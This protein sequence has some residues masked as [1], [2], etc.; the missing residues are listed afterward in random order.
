MD[1]QVKNYKLGIR[2]GEEHGRAKLS[3]HEVDLLRRMVEGGKLSQKEAADKF[4]ISKG[5]V[6][7]LV[8]Y[9]QR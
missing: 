3:D 6:S 1:G 8:S 9:K 5:H 7:K 2:I 4:E